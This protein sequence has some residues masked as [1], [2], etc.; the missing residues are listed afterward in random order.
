MNRDDV[1]VWLSLSCFVVLC[2]VALWALLRLWWLPAVSLTGSICQGYVGKQPATGG[3]KVI[4]L[5]AW[6][7]ASCSWL[8]SNP[9]PDADPDNRQRYDDYQ[10]VNH[11]PSGY[12][13]CRLGHSVCPLCPRYVPDGRKWLWT[14]SHVL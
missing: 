10:Y 4:T 1:L 14:S 12:A 7:S 13:L 8:G 9:D 2:G 11:Q 5:A 3:R 6:R